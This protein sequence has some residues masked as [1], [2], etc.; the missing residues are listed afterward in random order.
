MYGLG[1]LRHLDLSL[2]HWMILIMA[3]G[4]YI[5]AYKYR[6]NWKV[7]F[8]VQPF[9]LIGF[10]G[11]SIACFDTGLLFHAAK[12][13]SAYRWKLFITEF[14]FQNYVHRQ[15]PFVTYLISRVPV[16]WVWQCIF[17]GVSIFVC[18]ALYHRFERRALL[19]CATP[20]FLLMSTQPGN[21]FL[22]FAYLAGL[23]LFRKQ[24]FLFSIL[25][26]ISFLIKPL[27][28][29]CVPIIMLRIR[30]YILVSFIVIFIYYLWSRNY[31]FGYL[32]WNFLAH[33]LGLRALFEGI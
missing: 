17:C 9:L 6:M 25:F 19:I 20:V 12:Y 29:L 32:Q 18:W 3:V 21:D 2:S 30:A 16:L 4:M 8:G 23:L 22:L 24:K 5:F 28:L 10:W 31:H 14:A 13:L 15:P 33:Q 11:K 1:F 7:A 26:G 27:M